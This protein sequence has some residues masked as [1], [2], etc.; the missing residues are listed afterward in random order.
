MK[1]LA[2]T[3]QVAR[4][5][6]ANAGL[7]LRH[8]LTRQ[9]ALNV[10]ACA[11]M[12]GGSVAHA[13]EIE[14]RAYSNAPVGVN[15]LIAG[16]VFTQGGLA[17]DPALP[18]KDPELD[19]SNAVIGY[20]RVIDLWGMSG[21][22]DAIVPYTWLSGTA[23]L[24]GQPIERVVDG[25]ADPKFRLSVNL[26]GAPSLSLQEF[27][28]Y[29][30]DL[31]IGASLQVSAPLG[32]YDSSRVVNIG[33]N[34][35]SFKPELGVSK[36]L[37]R[38]TME[39]AAAATLYTDNHDFYGGSTRSQDP[40]YSLQGHA[41]YNFRSGIWGSLDANY[42]AGG[43]TTIDDTLNHDLQQ[44]WRVGGTLA[45]PLDRLNSIKLYAS[46]GVSARTGNDFDLAGIAWQHRWGG[47]L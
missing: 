15:F 43:R 10:I 47:G 1:Y 27:A 8:L 33:S 5:P 3:L 19:T 24:D 34:R 23:S 11:L 36:T 30:Q 46:S 14:P 18:V 37:G 39:I 26:I 28:D 31:I 12:A 40:I 25:F 22:F 42:F 9:H 17:F 32:Q 20:A 6:D 13:Q 7:P 45:F 16:Y 2:K 4:C 21:K 29:Q 44:N 38:W 35:W 41:I